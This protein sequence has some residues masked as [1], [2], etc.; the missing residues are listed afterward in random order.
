MTWTR[1]DDTLH[2]HPKAR[3]AG[4][5]ALGL[6]LLALSYCG[7]HLTDGFVDADWLEEKLR[8]KQRQLPQRLVDAGLWEDRE[9]GFQIHDWHDFNP[10]REEIVAKRTA[11]QQA[12][13]K[14]GFAKAAG[15]SNGLANA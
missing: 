3:R 5:P 4:L 8:G 13:R 7:Q 10:T 2:S 11:R 9:G 15:S 1:V 6:H 12:G 14:G